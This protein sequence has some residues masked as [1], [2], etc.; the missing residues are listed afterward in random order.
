M[1]HGLAFSLVSSEGFLVMDGS[2]RYLT[3]EC[4]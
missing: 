3:T 1:D 2:D 4:I